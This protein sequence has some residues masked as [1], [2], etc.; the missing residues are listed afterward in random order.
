MKKILVV[1]ESLGEPNHKRGIFHFTRELIR[2]LTAEGH[3]LTLVVET[4]NFK[5]V[6]AYRGGSEYLKLVERFTPTG[7]KTVQWSVTADDSHTWAR[8][9]TMELPFTA[10]KERIFEYACHEGNRAIENFLRGA[11]AEEKRKSQ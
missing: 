9:W 2:S 6:S 4:T 8:P 5:P 7:P 3:E 11:R 1:S 10:T